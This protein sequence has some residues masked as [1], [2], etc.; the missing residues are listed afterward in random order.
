MTS[1]VI[2]DSTLDSLTPSVNAP[3]NS[4]LDFT[5]YLVSTT[6]GELAPTHDTW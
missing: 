3:L 4:V 1:M 6:L 5:T 2:M